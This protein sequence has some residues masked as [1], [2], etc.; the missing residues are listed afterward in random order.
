MK[1]HIYIIFFLLN[2]YSN[3]VLSQNITNSIFDKSL[4]NRDLI[5]RSD[6]KSLIVYN[7][8]NNVNYYK[9]NKN[10]FDCNLGL[11]TIAMPIGSILCYQSFESF[12]SGNKNEGYGF[13]IAG[14]VVLTSYTTIIIYCRH[15]NKKNHPYNWNF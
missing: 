10:K 11:M 6:F 1:S 8:Y 14:G 13:M 9:I 15:K 4:N 12:K 5:I 2:C 3:I 7:N